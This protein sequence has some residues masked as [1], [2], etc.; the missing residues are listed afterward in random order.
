MSA[1]K[2]Q[3]LDRMSDFHHEM[4]WQTRCWALSCIFV[5]S[6]L[7][8]TTDCMTIFVKQSWDGDHCNAQETEQARRP[9]NSKIVI[10]VRTEKRK[11]RPE[12]TSHEGVGRDSRIGKLQI[13]VDDVVQTLNKHH[14]QTDT[15]RHTA[16]DHAGP[17]NLGIRSPGEDEESN[18]YEAASSDHHWKAKLGDNDSL[19]AF[20]CLC[21]L[22]LRH[23]N[24]GKSTD[25]HT[26]KQA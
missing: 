12:K 20:R 17:M 6:I 3:S 26:Y 2:L 22:C 25:K 4:S 10:H 19:V 16:N 5:H 13:D 23:V 18:W 15:G 21:K 8:P 11:G 7:R 9:R 14:K 24:D 1:V